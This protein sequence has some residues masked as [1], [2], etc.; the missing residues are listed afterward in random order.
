MFYALIRYPPVTVG[1]VVDLQRIARAV[2][3]AQAALVPVQRLAGLSFGGPC[4]RTHVPFVI[5]ASHRVLVDAGEERLALP[6]LALPCPANAEPE[7]AKPSLDL[8]SPASY[9]TQN[10][11]HLCCSRLAEGAR[12]VT[13]MFGVLSASNEK[14]AAPSAVPVYHSQVVPVNRG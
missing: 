9:R 6:S 1:A 12:S 7:H 3:I 10:S 2:L 11:E 5:A 13:Q 14:T 4:G 8:P